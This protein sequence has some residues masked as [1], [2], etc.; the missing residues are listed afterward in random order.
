MTCQFENNLEDNLKEAF[1]K[2]I[3]DMT[4]KQKLLGGKDSTWA[5]VQE[6]AVALEQATKDVE[7]GNSQTK[8]VSAVKKVYM[9]HAQRYP[10][11]ERC[12]GAHHSSKCPFKQA[13]CHACHRKGHIKRACRNI[14]DKQPSKQ[15]NNSK[16]GYQRNKNRIH[17]VVETDSE[18]E[19]VT[20]D[21]Y[22]ILSVSDNKSK[23]Y[24]VMM[25]VEGKSVD[26]AVDTQAAVSVVSEE[27]YNKKFN[28]CTLK[29]SNV[30]LRSYSD[31][32]VAVKGKIDVEVEY[33]GKHYNLP[34][35]VVKGHKDSL[36]G[37]SWLQEIKLDWKEIFSTEAKS[38]EEVVHKHAEVFNKKSQHNI[39][40]GYTAQINLK[41]GSQP[42]FRKARPVPYA[43]RQAVE[44]NLDKAVEQGILKPVETSQ[45][46]SPI[47][48]T[49]KADN[50]V[51]ICGDYK[52]TVNL[53]IDDAIYPLP[54]PTDIFATLVGGRIFSVLD[55]SNAFQQIQLTESSKEL[56]TINT[57]KGLFRYE[58]LPYGVKVAAQ[59][60]QSMMDQILKGLEGVSCFIDDILIKSPDLDSHL[61]ILDQVLQRLENSGVLVNKDKCQFAVHQ[62][63]YLG[64]I[65]DQDGIRTNKEKVEAIQAVT[66]PKNVSELK[67]FLGAATYY[68]K[69][70][71]GFAT[72][73]APLYDLTKT[74]TKWKWSANCESAFCKIKDM[75]ASDIVLTYYDVNKPLYLATDASPY[76]VAAVLSHKDDNGDERP[77]M[78]ASR[79]LSEAEKI[80]VKLKGRQLE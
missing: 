70:L 59:L 12:L 33:N 57:C 54:L 21:V 43:L 74:S 53:Q 3:R 37:K 62:V 18:T 30:V 78:Y 14:A 77:I 4:I 65:I 76:G 47:V 9:G 67:T 38:V 24:K 63:T 17:Q 20:Y 49:P 11:C 68:H 23:D 69:F 64:H 56:L 45:W 58:R 31:H 73:S 44:Q 19:D 39:I 80:T 8:Q 42:V 25:K 50:N 71:P 55:L 66:S 28:H 22:S 10:P 34:L 2:G 72:I 60:F 6:E 48:V 13:D 7:L 27:L 75:L 15:A 61:T 52:R 32:A 29:S 36:F 41:P 51:R 26:F 35:Y 40:K 46:A 5:T 79:T 1:I 16:T